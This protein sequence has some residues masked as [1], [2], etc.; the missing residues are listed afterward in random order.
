L[1]Y[2]PQTEDDIRQ[3][4]ETI[5][6]SSIE[7]LFACIPEKL[8]TQG[9]LDLPSAL[10]EPELRREMQRLAGPDP[11]PCFL[12]AG[13]YPHAVPAAVE[14]LLLRNE[15]YTAYTPYQPEV[16]QGTLQSMFEFQTIVAELLD[17]DVANASMY[18]G[19]TATAEAALMGLR[20][21]RDRTKIVLSSTLHPEYRAV[22]RTLVSAIATEV[23]EVPRDDESGR[24]DLEALEKSANDAAV[25]VVQS[26]NFLGVVEDGAEIGRI[27]KRA[28]TLLVVAV[29][30]IMSLGVLV[31]PGAYGA[32]IATGEGLGWG[33]GVQVGGPACGLFAARQ[34]HV[35]QMPGR[36][37]GETVDSDGHRG[38]VLTLS[39]R[40][41]HIRR[42]KATSNICTN[43]GLLALAFA[44]HL[45]LL[46]KQGFV[47]ASR[48]NLA[49]ALAVKK[50]FSEIGLAP[51]FSG[52]TF[53]EVAYRVPNGSA[54][55]LQKKVLAERGIIAGL[56]LARFHPELEDTL[57]VCT[58]EVHSPAE[59][60]G[61]VEGVKRALR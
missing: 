14:Q 34:A 49:R 42:E 56:P 11:G 59:V 33:V 7:E 60:D 17:L 57:L 47:A 5:G 28:G 24:T 40:E 30:E 18:D 4:L 61:L 48:Q 19:S 26:P 55:E 27:A 41:Q 52:P 15:L 31:P 51:R 36:L 35:R 54:D 2:L 13:A 3:M 1:R 16:A 9:S 23:V 53:N 10:S 38:Y 39:T 45:A 44:M 37:V 22:V 46:G 12:G 50:R 43:Q 8:R 20:I 29:P 6:V 25:I 32:D 21:A 58:T